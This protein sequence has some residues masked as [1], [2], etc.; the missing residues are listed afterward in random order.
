MDHC[1]DCPGRHL[2]RRVAAGAIRLP[3]GDGRA[4]AH[5]YGVLRA[6]AAVRS[7][8]APGGGERAA[9]ALCSGR[10]SGADGHR[11]GQRAG[12]GH[13]AHAGVPRLDLLRAGGRAGR[14]TV[15]APARLLRDLQQD[16]RAG[17]ARPRTLRLG[18][19]SRAGDLDDPGR[20]RDVGRS[21]RPTDIRS[22]QCVGIGGI[23][24]PQQKRLRPDRGRRSAVETIALRIGKTL[25]KNGIR[26]DSSGIPRI[27]SSV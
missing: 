8:G 24:S 20:Q 17:A 5:R 14:G 9:D 10:H 23:R 6:S 11:R 21:L 22:I 19:G 3:V 2:P 25:L 16:G 18:S 13:R 12:D 7:D 15:G 4:G 26:Q 1:S 27:V